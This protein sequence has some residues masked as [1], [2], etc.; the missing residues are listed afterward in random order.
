MVP[1]DSFYRTIFYPITYIRSLFSINHITSYV[2]S[3]VYM[4]CNLDPVS[5]IFALFLFNNYIAMSIENTRD[6]NLSPSGY[7]YRSSSVAAG[8]LH[9]LVIIHIHT[10]HCCCTQLLSQVTYSDNQTT[11]PGRKRTANK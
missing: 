1:M 6:R 3:R 7:S 9:Y 11:T 5:I 8:A 2:D 10:Q 4:V